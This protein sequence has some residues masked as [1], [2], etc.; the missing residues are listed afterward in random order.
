MVKLMHAK[1][2]LEGVLIHWTIGRL[3]L[4]FGG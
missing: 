1:S 3:R 4:F 2:E